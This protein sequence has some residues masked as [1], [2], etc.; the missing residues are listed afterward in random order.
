MSDI[1]LGLIT[2][3]TLCVLASVVCVA[4]GDIDYGM[5]LIFLGWINF[6]ASYLRNKPLK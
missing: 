6:I 2:S 1:T 5:L 4:N 3:G